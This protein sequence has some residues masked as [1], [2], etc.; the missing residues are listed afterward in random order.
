MTEV[1]VGY[2]LQL[3]GTLFYSYR[4]S[5]NLELIDLVYSYRV[6]LNLEL[7]SLAVSSLKLPVS[8]PVHQWDHRCLPSHPALLWVS[9]I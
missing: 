5:L 2:L 7:M 4:V 9:G 8:V 1:N 6:S 3:H